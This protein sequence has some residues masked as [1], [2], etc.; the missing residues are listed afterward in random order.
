MNKDTLRSTF[1]KIQAD[2]SF[3]RD[4]V[5]F[6]DKN[7][8]SVRPYEA[9]E[10]KGKEVNRTLRR[11]IIFA[12]TVLLFG[13]SITLAILLSDNRA[14]VMP[15]TATAEN[16]GVVPQ[17]TTGSELSET[18]ATTAETT[19]VSDQNIT[20]IYNDDHPG[21]FSSIEDLVLKSNYVFIGT[22]SDVSP[23]VRINRADYNLSV[24]AGYEYSNITTSY[25]NVEE[26]L[27]G[28]LQVGDSFQVDQFG[29]SAEGVNDIW[30]NV[31]YPTEGGKYLVFAIS[32]A[33][34]GG[35]KHFE[36]Q[37]TGAFDGFYE[38]SDT[39]LI[40]Q[41]EKSF[42]DAGQS[43]ENALASIREVTDILPPQVKG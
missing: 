32:A 17:T 40:P 41:N 10:Y 14:E 9:V 42:F 20:S 31:T 11:V 43:L 1:S 7:L 30:V 38:I 23:A 4:T 18:S 39:T 12:A 34:I 36:N 37:F 21:T 27:F 2:P 15:Q 16:A 22:V 8:N 13:A 6:L 29:G 28:D 35:E 5:S 19:A 25:F 26:V 3:K 33:G 24:E